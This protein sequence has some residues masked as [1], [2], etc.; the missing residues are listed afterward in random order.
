MDVAQAVEGELRIAVSVREFP[1]PLGGR[2]LVHAG[3]VPGVDDVPGTL[4]VIRIVLLFHDVLPEGFPEDGEHGWRQRDHPVPGVGLCFGDEGP[5][6]R[7]IFEGAVHG[8][9]AGVPVHV[10]ISEGADLTQAQR[11][12]HGQEHG[13]LQGR[14]CFPD[15]Q[16]QEGDD[17]LLREGGLFLF[18]LL[19]ALDAVHG[20]VFQEADA[21]GGGQ[22]GLHAA[23]VVEGGFDGQGRGGSGRQL[24]RL[25][26]GA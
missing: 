25:P 16:L 13:E 1:E 22:H 3:T 6:G 4:P 21:D 9:G 19:R 8:D 10:C 23:V 15:D 11:A 26:A 14:G 2:V 5:G 20:I 12:E 24:L 17:F 7:G 18:A